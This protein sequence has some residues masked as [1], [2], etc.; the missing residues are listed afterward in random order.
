MSEAGTTWGQARE[1][2]ISAMR[3]TCEILG[4]ILRNVSDDQARELRDGPDGWSVIE[5]LCHLRDFDEIFHSRALMML[6]REQPQ[7]PAYDHE[8]MA[9]DRAYQRE[10]V[11]DAYDALK[12]SRARFLEFFE[13]LRPEQW[14]RGG[15]HPERG[16]FSMTA[17]LMQV[18]AHDLDH[19]EQITR[20]LRGAE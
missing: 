1:R 15:V 5:V 13:R 3:L 20:I 7:L 17:A 4:H 11:V 6:E 8:G 18:S 14:A 19:L 12:N 2:Q 16:R 10:T 9:V